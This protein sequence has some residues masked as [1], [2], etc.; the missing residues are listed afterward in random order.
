VYN[1]VERK[2]SWGRQDERPLSIPKA[3]LHQK[4]AMLCFWWDWKGI[5][6]Y[7]L[8][9]RNQTINTDVYCSQLDRLKAAIDQKRPELVN[10]KGVVFH[11]DNATPHVFLATRQKLMQ[12]GWDVLPQPPYSPGLASSDYHSFRSLKNPLNGK[13]FTS[14]EACKNHLEQ[15]FA[16]KTGKFY[17]D[18]IIKLPER[19]L[20]FID[21]NGAYNDEQSYIYINNLSFNLTEKTER[22]FRSTQ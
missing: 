7:D 11:H 12:L 20:K 2:R 18:G 5:L 17:M 9:R 6:Y 1:N 10:R 22:T 21:K 4:K 13:N 16:R 15:F 3:E 19:R 14:L 8:L